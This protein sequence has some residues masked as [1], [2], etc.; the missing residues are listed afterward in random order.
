MARRVRKTP[1]SRTG[2]SDGQ[3]PRCQTCLRLGLE[4]VQFDIFCPINV[5]TPTRESR[6]RAVTDA[7]PEADPDES[8]HSS[9]ASTSSGS[10]GGTA[11]DAESSGEAADWH[12]SSGSSALVPSTARRLS[13]SSSRSSRSS[14]SSQSQYESQFQLQSSPHQNQNQNQHQHQHQHHQN[15][16]QNQNQVSLRARGGGSRDGPPMPSLSAFSYLSTS[17]YFFLQYYL[18]RLSNVLVNANSSVNPLKQLILPRIASSNLLLDAICATAAVHRSSANDV[19]RSE[20]STMATRY[21]VR[22]LSAVRDLIPRVTNNSS[23][24]SGSG[25]GSGSSR[26]REQLITDG[27]ESSPVEG[28]GSSDYG[29]G[30]RNNKNKNKNKRKVIIEDKD[31]AEM[32]IL[33]SIFLCKYEIIKDGVEN[34][35][36]HLRGIESLCQSL[37]PE[38]TASMSNTLAYVRSFM[39]YH[40]NIARVTEY[41]PHARDEEFEH[42]PFEIGTLFPVDPYMGFSQ[43]LIILLGRANDLLVIN[44]RDEPHKVKEEVEAI[45]SLLARRSW[46]ADRFAI[47]EGMGPLTIENSSHIAEAY[48]CAVIA[49]I[50][51]ALEIL[52]EREREGA[53]YSPLVP[54]EEL[55][56]HS[57]LQPQ[58]TIPLHIPTPIDWASLHALLPV[59]KAEALTDCLAAVA[60]VP[61]GCPEE[62][63]LLPLLFIIACETQV[64]D[65]AK[66]ALVRVE[67]L[68]S[69]IGLGN[70]RC[71]QML[72]KQVWARKS[73][74]RDFHDW[75]GLLAKVKWDLI[76][77]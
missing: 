37:D 9:P 63:G 26:R 45:L 10:S 40:K 24:G 73:V 54:M 57:Q 11:D 4:C 12:S 74:Q 48:R 68:G 1:W 58:S 13:Q 5:V 43:S 8:N 2:C 17:E 72:L 35:R 50:H 3:K 19:D 60:R 31:T 27:R 64:Q 55:S 44:I 69:H 15:Q 18:E 61:L 75:R 77:T 65:Q 67:A 30:N 46:S 14:R 47:P 28:E 39:S 20:Y 32:A 16:N 51:A 66:E 6:P 7:D 38:Q 49:C 70:V 42:E 23:S 62:A 56:L 59:E 76:I 21:Y 25:S 53:V 36:F 33:A 22:V 29:N 52:A 71:A 34:W 41:A